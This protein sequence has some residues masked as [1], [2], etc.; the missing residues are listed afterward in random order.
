MGMTQ[1]SGAERIWLQPDKDAPGHHW[2]LFEGDVVL[3]W[4]R[5]QLD[6]SWSWVIPG[7]PR[8]VG[9]E[10]SK[11]AAMKAVEAAIRA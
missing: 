4:I 11:P 3:A 5:P 2:Y 6:G 10:S 1:K 9:I 8:Q 7:E